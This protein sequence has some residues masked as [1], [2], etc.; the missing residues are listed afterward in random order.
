MKNITLY[1]IKR[2]MLVNFILALN[3]IIGGY[4]IYKVP[5][6]AFPGVSM[7]QIIIITKYPGA[8]SKDV[9]LNVTGKIEDKIAEIGNIK[10]FRS[11]SIESVSR[12]TIFANEDLNDYQFKDL[13]SDVQ[14]EVDKIDDFP[15][16]IEGQPIITSVTTEDRPIMEIAFTGSYD[17]LKNKLPQIEDDLRKVSGVSNVTTVGLADEEIH[18]EVNAKRAWKA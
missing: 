15:S 5:K 16:D 2:P 18:I 1:F 13:L 6:E 12:I 7:N 11:S 17:L 14:L 8:S 10:E 4:F 3:F 9:E